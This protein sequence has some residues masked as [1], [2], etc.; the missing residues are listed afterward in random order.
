MTITPSIW[1]L[2]GGGHAKVVIDAAELSGRPVSGFFDD[3]SEPAINAGITHLGTIESAGDRMSEDEFATV[4]LAIGHI[5]ARRRVMERLMGRGIQADR[6]ATII[7]PGAIV[8]ASVT[9]GRGVFIAPG[10]IINASARLSNHAI[11]NTA[12]VVE[13]DVS[14]GENSHVSPHATIC[15]GVR[16]GAHTL[17]GAGAVILPR[18]SIGEGVIVGAGAVV[19]RDVGD[20]RKVVGNPAH[21]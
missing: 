7:H 16:I 5:E 10:A 19:L 12:A 8:S 9:I 11:I 6:Y 2:G 3:D 15:G 4:H 14:V 17:I 1:L 21:G 20:G 18:V 13:H